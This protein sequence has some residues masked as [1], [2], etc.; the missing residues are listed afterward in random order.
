MKRMEVNLK[1]GLKQVYEAPK[2]QGKEVFLRTLADPELSVR[3]FLFGQLGYIRKW[4]WILAG[5]VFVFAVICMY[6]GNANYLVIFSGMVPF[7]AL[8]TVTESSRSIR[9]GMEELELAGRF[10][11]REIVMARLGILGAGNLLLLGVICPVLFWQRYMTMVQL[12]A[13]ILMPYLLTC[14]LSLFAVRKI[15]GRESG[16]VCCGI[17]VLMSAAQM[18]VEWMHI[19]VYYVLKPQRLAVILLLLLVL[20]G[21]ECIKTFR[22]SE[23]YVWNL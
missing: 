7:L 22:Q 9:Y 6:V 8:A 16:Y 21:R 3:E 15:R 11:L 10:S 5:M 17:A 19:Q 20:T 13:N 1:K 23:E 4:N 14:C 12:G 2:P 18:L